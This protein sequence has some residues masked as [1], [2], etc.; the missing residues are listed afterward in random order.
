MNWRKDRCFSLKDLFNDLI[1]LIP[2]YHFYN[3]F[4]LTVLDLCCYK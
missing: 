4:E 1:I 2:Q 3:I